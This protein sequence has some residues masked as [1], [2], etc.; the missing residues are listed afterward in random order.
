MASRDSSNTSRLIGR[1]LDEDGRPA[2]DVDVRLEPGP[3]TI[4]TSVDGAFAFDDLAS[5]TY[6]ASAR[7]DQFYAWPTLVDASGSSQS[8]TLQL[9]LG[10]TF[11][12]SVF[13]DRTPVIGAK[14]MLEHG[15]R[16]TTDA[17]GCAT[18]SGLAPHSYR[19]VLLADGWADEELML[20]IHDDPGGI[21]ERTLNLEPG[22]RIEGVVLDSNGKPVG[23][24]VV[25][26]WS[27][28]VGRPLLKPGR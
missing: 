27:G 28:N 22:A 23:E 26:A 9:R 13:A 17:T 25:L 11:I 24:A 3:H 16:A 7:K 6:S 12:V 2:G 15:I 20:S 14:L 18:V 4:T 10:A 19:G 8:V 5:R 1:V 21:V